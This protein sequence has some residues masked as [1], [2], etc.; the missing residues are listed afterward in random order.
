[1]WN[2]NNNKKMKIK[3]NEN[4]KKITEN[5]IIFPLYYLCFT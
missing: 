5:I 1:M 4:L 2:N 3:M